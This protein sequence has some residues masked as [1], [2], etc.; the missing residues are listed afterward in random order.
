MSIQIELNLP[1]LTTIDILRTIHFS[2]CLIGAVVFYISWYKSKDY[3]LP[4]RN[5]LLFVMSAL[6]IW[7]FM[8]L[9][10]ILGFMKPGQVSILLKILSTYNNALFLCAIPFLGLKKI[11]DKNVELIENS[12]TWVISILTSNIFIVILY[13]MFWGEN[14]ISNSVVRNLDVLYSVLTMLF[15]SGSMTYKSYTIEDSPKFYFVLNTLMMLMLTIP[16][17]SFLTLFNILHFEIISVILLISQSLLI[18]NLILLYHEIRSKS[19]KWSFEQRIQ[20]LN[21]ELSKTNTLLNEKV[22]VM[23]DSESQ[24]IALQVEVNALKSA[25]IEATEDTSYANMLSK[26]S[27]R[28]KEVLKYIG[29]SYSEIGMLLFISRETVISHKRNIESKLGIHTKEGL[30]EFAIRSGLVCM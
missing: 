19:R 28:E 5:S 15:L 13:S 29:K 23:A 24:L 26:L 12:N 10:R 21:Q 25:I 30:E 7:C 20:D 17:L 11:K 6:L 3:A 9:Y 16:Q 27:E 2:I 4:M 1:Q 14:G 8:D 22:A 18:T